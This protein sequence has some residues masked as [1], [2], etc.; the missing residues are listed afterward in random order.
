[1]DLSCYGSE[2]IQTPNIDSLSEHG[3][4]F[5][6]YHSNSSVST[7][8]R[9]ALLTGRYQQRSGLEGVI[10]VRGETRQTGMAPSEIT[11]ADVL[12]DAGYTT[13]IMG[14]W[15]LGYKKKFNPVH[16]GFDEFY[17]Y[18][19]GNIDY[20]SHY[21]NAG[22]YDWWHNLDTI[23][24]EGYVTDLITDHSVEFIRENKDRPFLLYIPHEAPHV[25]FQGRNDTAYR[26]PDRDFSYLGPVEDTAAT[27]R[28]MVEVMDEGV[29]RVMK[30]LRDLD[31]EEETFVVFCSDNGARF[32]SNGNLR[33][34]KGTLWEGGH[35][36]P[37]VA[38]WKGKIE[39]GSSD[40][41]AVSFDLFPTMLSIT[42]TKRPDTLSLDGIDLSPLLFQGETLPER[43]VVWR[44]R[45]QKAVR[46]GK[47]KL[48]IT[49]SDTLLF[50]LEADRYESNDL[51]PENPGKVEE[52]LDEYRQW[53]ADVV[54]G[55]T[56]RTD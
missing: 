42:N 16:Q 31:L 6:D 44:Y 53:K 51:A 9:A 40:E 13:G 2:Y 22:I 11:F 52:L 34:D 25:P 19:S 35:R 55:V 3:L 54:K 17:G 26:Y 32:G 30:T 28:E 46:K 27:Y 18:V 24:E 21:D 41:L 33:G 12:K 45:G 14:K 8:T 43:T 1:G 5:T 49:E 20:H 7:P 38:Y 39:P 10:Y 37:A 47:W 15:H 29:G 56:M 4:T 23:R 48:M 36:V 50:D